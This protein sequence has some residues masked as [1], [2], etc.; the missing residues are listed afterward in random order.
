MWGS[1]VTL[2]PCRSHT[3]EVFWKESWLHKVNTDRYDND[4]SKREVF[5]QLS[6]ISCSM[7]GWMYT[8]PVDLP[9][10]LSQVHFLYSREVFN[11]SAFPHLVSTGIP[12]LSLKSTSLGFQHI[13]KTAETPS[14][15]GLR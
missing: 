12:T 2:L 1:K 8:P 7:F 14:L 3:A 15:V 11:M 6:K 5:L 10:A 9:S 13:H 4:F